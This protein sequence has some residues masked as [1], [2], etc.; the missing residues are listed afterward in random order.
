MKN[1]LFVLILL[2]FAI[3]SNAEVQGQFDY[4]NFKARKVAFITTSVNLTSSEAEK[5][6]PVYNEYEQ[7]KYSLMQERKEIEANMKKKADA[8][9]DQECIEISKKFASFKKIEGDLEMEYNEKFLKILS[10][11]KVVK[12]SVAEMDFKGH[13][14]REYKKD[15]DDKGDRK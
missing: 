2:S 11:Q 7:K 12:L 15:N 4:E 3:I 10:P 13:L 5:F 1:L 6:W 14:L 9:T 8:L